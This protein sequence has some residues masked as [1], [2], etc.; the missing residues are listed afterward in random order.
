MPPVRRMSNPHL[1]GASESLCLLPAVHFVVQLTR[2]G[3]PLNASVLADL[4]DVTEEC[5]KPVWMCVSNLL[6]EKGPARQ[7]LVFVLSVV[8]PLELLACV[9]TMTTGIVD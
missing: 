5:S 6:I 9:E 8:T 4:S 1:A 3:L 2:S 7:L